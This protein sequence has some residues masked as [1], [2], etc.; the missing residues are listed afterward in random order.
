MAAIALRQIGRIYAEPIPTEDQEEAYRKA[1]KRKYKGAVG[2]QNRLW[3]RS[4]DLQRG[5]YKTESVHGRA[6]VAIRGISQDRVRGRHNLGEPTSRGGWKPKRPAL[7]IVRHNPWMQEA[8]DIT[9]PEWK[10]LYEDGIRE[11]LRLAELGK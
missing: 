1:G 6:E 3:E 4:G 2:G 8:M 10:E 11:H 5:L 7:G 9:E